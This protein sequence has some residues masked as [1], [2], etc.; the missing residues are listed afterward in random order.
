MNEL[1]I[2]QDDDREGWD[3]F[4]RVCRGLKSPLSWEKGHVY[5]AAS[6]KDHHVMMNVHVYEQR[7]SEAKLKSCSDVK[8][9]LR[10]PERVCYELDNSKAEE[11]FQSHREKD[12]FFISVP[13]NGPEEGGSCGLALQKKLH[14]IMA[15]MSIVQEFSD[16]VVCAMRSAILKGIA[17]EIKRLLPPDTFVCVV[18]R[19]QLTLMP[20]PFE[21]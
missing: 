16:N 2:W 9:F 15:E 14:A 6:R 20:C 4:R 5:I 7:A 17:E 12:E 1:N 19:L 10:S 3:S 8:E 21:I 18:F 11:F 13:L